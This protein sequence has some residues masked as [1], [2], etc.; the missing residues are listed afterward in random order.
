[1]LKH[2]EGNIPLHSARWRSKALGQKRGRSKDQKEEG[3]RP[4]HQLQIKQEIRHLKT[5]HFFHLHG[6]AKPQVGD[7]G[8]GSHINILIPSHGFYYI[9]QNAIL[10][11]YIQCIHARVITEN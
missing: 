4:D 1:M 2:T 6:C 11:L 10:T 8:G 7:G 5:S 3:N 9:P